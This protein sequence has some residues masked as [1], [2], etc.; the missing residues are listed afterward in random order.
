M[1][2]R[3]KETCSNVAC[4]SITNNKKYSFYYAQCPVYYL[5]DISLNKNIRNMGVASVASWFPAY[6]ISSTS[7]IIG[8]SIFY[9]YPFT[10][11][12]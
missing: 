11:H 6:F 8:L 4:K 9:E 3:E 7:S 1:V 10:T 12:S 2:F 5:S